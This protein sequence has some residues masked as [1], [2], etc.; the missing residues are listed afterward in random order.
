[1]GRN[2]VDEVMS[3]FAENA[4]LRPGPYAPVSGHDAI[5]VTVEG[6]F[7][8]G[9]CVDHEILFIATAGAVVLMERI[10]HWIING[11][12]MAIPHTWGL[13][14]RRTKKSRPGVSTSPLPVTPN[15]S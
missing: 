8:G 1:M 14:R 9:T 5:R 7:S 13:A 15:V 12:T 10:D 2:D 6:Y 4:T 11:K 3:Y